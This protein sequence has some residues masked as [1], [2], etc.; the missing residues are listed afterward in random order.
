MEYP[1]QT[2]RSVSGWGKIGKY[3]LDTIAVDYPGRKG[4]DVNTD[5]RKIIAKEGLIYLGV[6]LAIFVFTYLAQ[7]EFLPYAFGW[8]L[9]YVAFRFIWW[10]LK[11][12]GMLGNIKAALF[13]R[14]KKQTSDSLSQTVDSPKKNRD[15]RLYYGWNWLVWWKINPSALEWQV[16][17]YT[18]LKI[19]RSARG[20]S[21][22]F[23][24]GSA[25][26]TVAFMMWLFIIT[27][28]YGLFPEH[29]SAFNALLLVYVPGTILVSVLGFFIYRGHRWAMIAM[30]ALLTI[31]LIGQPKF[32]IFWAPCMHAFYAAL[33]VENM[34]KRQQKA[35]SLPAT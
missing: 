27:W 3:L 19:T 14:P 28:H 35:C 2:F 18:T 5:N 4:D 13:R 20:L 34:R 24:I 15:I 7:E 22:L 1:F 31:K 8:S 11:T 16:E 17:N 23:C 32:I 21:L 6:V 33:K 30:M 9:I 12:L 29:S 25:V 10:A 26:V